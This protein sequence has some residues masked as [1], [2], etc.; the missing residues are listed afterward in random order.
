MDVFEVL[1]AVSKR[2]IQF[3]R[4]GMRERDALK[5]AMFYVSIDY[6]IL[7]NDIKKLYNSGFGF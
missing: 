1:K 3:M 2:K 4:V 6:H 7:L 5:H